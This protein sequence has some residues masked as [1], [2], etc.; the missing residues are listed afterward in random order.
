MDH[1]TLF[2]HWPSL[3]CSNQDKLM[4]AAKEKLIF[5]ELGGL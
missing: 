5:N 3:A 1:V 2:H 4:Q